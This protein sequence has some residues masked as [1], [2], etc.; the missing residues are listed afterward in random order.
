MKAHSGLANFPLAKL[1]CETPAAS[2]GEACSL[3]MVPT[4]QQGPAHRVAL[5]L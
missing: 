2:W 5:N 4:H 3:A 1:A